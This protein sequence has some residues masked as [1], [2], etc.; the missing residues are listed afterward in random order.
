MTTNIIPTTR[1]RGPKPMTKRAKVRRALEKG[2]PVDIIVKRYECH[3]S[4]VY[5]ERRRMKQ[6]AA[7]LTITPP[8]G[9]AA[10][11]ATPSPVANTGLVTLSGPV[12][13]EKI[14]PP[15]GLFVEVAPPMSRWKRFW[16]WLAGARS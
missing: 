16:R 12:A 2:V 6:E 3:P 14:V 5:E 15:P 7:G 11:P 13:E 9:I 1:K 10:L 4:L 8:G